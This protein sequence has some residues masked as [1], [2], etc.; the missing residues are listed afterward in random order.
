MKIYNFFQQ[1]YGSFW[2]KDVA[3]NGDAFFKEAFRMER[4]KFD[5]L[6]ENLKGLQ[7]KDTN[8]RLCI[9]LAK[10]IAIALYA[11][12]S[13]A[14]YHTVGSLF[15]VSKA[16]VCRILLEFCEEVWRV[17]AP[18]YLKSDF[19]TEHKI[20]ECV[21]GFEALGFPQCLGAMGKQNILF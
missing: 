16:S 18:K 8:F 11:L 17:L 19:L 7:K 12:G 2:E 10:R 9:P 15:G 1:R 5:I 20:E 4:S 14:E 21:K 13:S 3:M 6:V